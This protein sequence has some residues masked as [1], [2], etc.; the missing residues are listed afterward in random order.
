MW[1]SVVFFKFSESDECRYSCSDYHGQRHRTAPSPQPFL[2][3]FTASL[4]SPSPNPVATTV[5][6]PMTYL[7]PSLRGTAQRV[8]FSVCRLPLSA[9]L[10]STHY[11]CVCVSQC[12]LILQ[13]MDIWTDYSCWLFEQNCCKHSGTALYVHPASSF[14]LGTFPSELVV[15]MV[16]V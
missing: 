14:I 13:S 2:G 6:C 10:S 11:Y 16:N 5:F 12:L 3:P 4:V 15:C 9:C 7:L 8:V 1:T